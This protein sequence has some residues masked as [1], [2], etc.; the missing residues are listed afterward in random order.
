MRMPWDKETLTFQICNKKRDT[1]PNLYVLNVHDKVVFLQENKR[2][3]SQQ[4]SKPQLIAIATFGHDHAI[5]PNH[6][7]LEFPCITMKGSRVTFYRITITC[8]LVDARG[9]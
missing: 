3:N 2:N 1:I 5:N 4:D 7:V 8:E 6:N 9:W